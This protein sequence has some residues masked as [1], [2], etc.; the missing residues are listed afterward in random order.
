MQFEAMSNKYDFIK[1]TSFVFLKTAFRVESFW[2]KLTF[3]TSE[4]RTSGDFEADLKELRNRDGSVLATSVADLKGI[5]A[6]WAD[7]LLT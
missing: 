2:R 1:K 4:Q 5:I 7:S 3:Q 6:T